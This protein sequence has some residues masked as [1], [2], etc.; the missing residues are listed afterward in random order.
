MRFAA[1]IVYAL[2]LIALPATASAQLVGDAHSTYS[3]GVLVTTQDVTTCPYRMV[4]TV[5]ASSSVEFS[6]SE[7]SAMFAKL[8]NKAIK[9][10]ADAVVLVNLGKKHITAFSFG[11]RDAIGRAIQYVDK[12]CA[13][14]S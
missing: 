6:S 9:L 11:K 13:P 5:S 8:R 4:G 3:E 14:Q 7:Q 1:V 12:S 10:G 2:I